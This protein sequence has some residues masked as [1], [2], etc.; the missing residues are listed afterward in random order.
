VWVTD[1]GIMF[2]LVVILCQQL[3]IAKPRSKIGMATQFDSCQATCLCLP[4]YYFCHIHNLA[5]QRYSLADGVVSGTAAGNIWH[6]CA[7]IVYWVIKAAVNRINMSYCK[8]TCT[9]DTSSQVQ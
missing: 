4:G 2:I 6:G 1:L 9:T 8:I 5:H 7:T 3:F